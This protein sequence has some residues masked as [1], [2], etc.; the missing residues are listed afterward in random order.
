MAIDNIRKKFNSILNFRKNWKLKNPSEKW[1]WIYDMASIGS[2]L[3]GVRVF[4]TNKRTLYSYSTVFSI[5]I[6]FLSI[7]NAFVHYASNG[8]IF[9]GLR[10]FGL[11]S[12]VVPVSEK[13]REKC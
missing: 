6:F 3:V 12:I 9:H 5:C 1:Y 11:T 2:E 10:G 4:T 13:K 8:Q 7:L